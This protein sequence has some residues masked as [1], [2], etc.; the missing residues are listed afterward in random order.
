MFTMREFE[1]PRPGADRG[2]GRARTARRR[3]RPGVEAME[4]RQLLAAAP[5]F[6]IAT[7]TAAEVAPTAVAEATANRVYLEFLMET[8]HA[9]GLDPAREARLLGQLDAGAPR[10]RVAA[11]LMR[12]PESATHMVESQYRAFLGRAPGPAE[13][14][15]MLGLV[16][17]GGDART[18]FLAIATGREYGRERAG[19]TAAGFVRAVYQDALRRPAGEAEV[20]SWLRR[21]AA[22]ASPAEVARAIV[23]S[24]ESLGVGARVVL[25]GTADAGSPPAGRRAVQVLRR[26]GGL[27]RLRAAYLGDPDLFARVT[28]VDRTRPPA[29]DAVSD[30]MPPDI[31]ISPILNLGTNWAAI[32]TGSGPVLDGTNLVAAGADGSIWVTGPAGQRDRLF[33]L[34]AS[35]YTGGGATP[36]AW[37]ALPTLPFQV[38][39]PSAVSEDLIYAVANGSIYRIDGAGNATAVATPPELAGGFTRVSA[40]LDGTLMAI[41]GDAMILQFPG[42]VGWTVLPQP[43]LVLP[44]QPSPFVPYAVAAGSAASVYGIFSVD[45]GNEL[46]FFY[47]F[48]DGAWTRLESPVRDPLSYSATSDGALWAWDSD[49]VSV[50]SPVTGEWQLV[51]STIV[52]DGNGVVTSTPVVAPGAMGV[53]AAISQD[54]LVVALGPDAAGANTVQVLTLGVADRLAAPIL[55]VD[56]QEAAFYNDISTYLGTTGPG[57]IRGLYDTASSTTLGEFYAHLLDMPTPASVNPSNRERWDAIY[58]QVLNELVYAP[59]VQNLFDSLGKINSDIGT[60]NATNLPAIV[61]L[62]SASE[63]IPAASKLGLYLFDVIEAMLAGIV[64]GLTGSAGV[65]GSIMASAFNSAVS[66]ATGQPNPDSN[67]ALDIDYNQ[68][69]N[70][71]DALYNSVDKTNLAY[72]TAILTDWARLSALGPLL[73]GSDPIWAPPIGSESTLADAAE[74]AFEQFF[75]RVLLPAKWQLVSI[76]SYTFA[77]NVMWGGCVPSSSTTFVPSYAIESQQIGSNP[78]NSSCPIMSYYFMN[79]VKANP[80]PFSGSDGPYPTQALLQQ[81]YETF[82]VTKQTLLTGGGGLNLQVVPGPSNP[83]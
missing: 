31:R 38:L 13:V 82:G 44:D 9:H 37:R 36:N 59:A 68:L 25:Y 32:D 79:Q 77:V 4:A 41:S 81:L 20:R 46:Y 76:P 6:P 62:I 3:C 2:Q 55:P 67:T 29:V 26:P 57:G 83:S 22:G 60:K 63:P 19:G 18:V 39:M 16:R 52:S 10:S 53:G 14:R 12:S 75:Y 43:P 40:A 70:T 7:A 17:G 21:L 33:V 64:K 80:D 48:D 5:A 11:E 27:D 8:L 51:N 65:I 23:F 30:P 66:L 49:H 42:Q 24:P 72:E 35:S 78:N 74:P 28:L 58:N 73:V 71:L 34:P 1:T 45:A 15:R 47:S 61:T 54:R 50:R 56:P 69:V